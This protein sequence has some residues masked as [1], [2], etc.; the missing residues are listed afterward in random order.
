[1]IEID[2]RQNVIEITEEINSIIINAIESALRHQNFDKPYEVSV[3]ITDN[4][5]IHEIN[6][7]FRNIDRPTDVL[8]FPMLD[9]LEDEIN[10]NIEDTNPE[11]GEVILGDIV[12]SIEKAYSQAEEYCHSVIREVAFLTVHSVLHLLGYDHEIDEDRIIMRKLEDAILD[13]MKLYR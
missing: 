4:P 2:N 12:I 6:L 9:N 8:S 5:G 7:E 3:V 11:S 13:D 10:I 1:M